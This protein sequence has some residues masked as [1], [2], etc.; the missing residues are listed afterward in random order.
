[1]EFERIYANWCIKYTH[2]W[3]F[4][5]SLSLSVRVILLLHLFGV[6]LAWFAYMLI[7]SKA[8][9]FQCK[10]PQTAHTHTGTQ[11]THHLFI[12]LMVFKFCKSFLKSI[13]C[14][15]WCLFFAA[16]EGQ[17]SVCRGD[18]QTQNSLVW[19]IKMKLLT[20]AIILVGFVCHQGKEFSQKLSKFWFSR[21]KIFFFPSGLLWIFWTVNHFQL[22][23][24]MAPWNFL[25]KP[26][27]WHDFTW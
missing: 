3:V 6:S 2:F 23:V 8:C 13:W 25:I 27:N 16:L 9:R 21:F 26:N 14:I 17:Y 11:T 12:D 19:N 20:T 7:V 4:F 22:Y 18:N 24:E 1:M 5:C 15:N 10:Q